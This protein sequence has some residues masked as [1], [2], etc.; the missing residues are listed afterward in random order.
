MIE[1]M[2][3][4]NLKFYHIT[5]TSNAIADC[6]SRLTRRIREAQHFQ[7]SDPIL[8]DYVMVNKLK[9]YK[10]NNEPDDPWVRRLATA[11]MED[12]DYITMIQHIETGT[13]P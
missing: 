9:G 11:A 12:T 13:E 8:A 4:F 3:C 6:F 2:M 5:G 1:N 7:L 10:E